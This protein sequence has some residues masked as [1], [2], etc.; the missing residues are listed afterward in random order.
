MEVRYKD[1][2]A[3]AYIRPWANTHYMDLFVTAPGRYSSGRSMSGLCGTFNG[4]ADDDRNNLGVARQFWVEGT[5]HSLFKNPSPRTMTE[6]QEEASSFCR[7]MFE[8]N[9]P[10]FLY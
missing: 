5:T 3:R 4:N 9:S 2:I 10:L 7:S 6:L 1:S 8:S